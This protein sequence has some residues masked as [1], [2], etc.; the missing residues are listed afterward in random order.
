MH[1]AR[2][3][4]H[5]QRYQPLRA[6]ADYVIQIVGILTRQ[7]NGSG[8]LAKLVEDET[9]ATTRWDMRGVNHSSVDGDDLGGVGAGCVTV[10]IYP[11]V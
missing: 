2:H 7:H 8:C 4:K 10:A 5:R 9:T 1:G 11:R 3:H 6:A